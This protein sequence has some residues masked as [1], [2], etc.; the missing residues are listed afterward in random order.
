MEKPNTQQAEAPPQPPPQPRAQP[1]AQPRCLTIAGSDSGGGAGIQADLKTFQALGCF[2]MSAITAL[3]AQNTVGVQGVLPVEAAFVGEQIRS[4]LGDIGADAVKIGM[5]HNAAVIEVVA[6]ELDGLEVPIVLDPVMVATSGDLL[7]ED[8]A[9]AALR[10]LLLPRV[11]LITPNLPEAEVLLGGAFPDAA[12]SAAAL[13]E[14]T[15]AA[16]VKGGH[17]QGENSVDVLAL[18]TPESD[19]PA[20]GYAL[21][22][23]SA[24]R[25]ATRNTHGTGCTLSSAIC[26]YLARGETLPDAVERAKAFLTAALVR[27]ADDELGSGHGPVR[28]ME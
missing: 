11:T 16:L 20:Q 5:L 3:T 14:C 28:W 19:N 6:Q 25:V 8:T 23:F 10:E 27:G 2:G 1:R 26:A 4:V 22:S 17:G 21:H 18:R 12:A 24:Q 9:V 15:D 7:L 13:L